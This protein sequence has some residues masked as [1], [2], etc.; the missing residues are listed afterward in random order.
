M[1]KTLALI[2]IVMMVV[3]CAHQS[4]SQRAEQIKAELNQTYPI[5]GIPFYE[6]DSLLAEIK[7]HVPPD[8]AILSISVTKHDN[9][10]HVTTGAIQNP[11]A[12]SG[13]IFILEKKEG[14][15]TFVKKSLW[16]S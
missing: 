7:K 16:I 2:I 13:T 3:S 12:G 1:P 15:W 8:V 9:T 6:F 4:S 11:L 10:V 5:D 14:N